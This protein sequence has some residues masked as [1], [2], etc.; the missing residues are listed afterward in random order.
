MAGPLSA[1]SPSKLNSRPQSF[2]SALVSLDSPTL[3]ALNALADPAETPSHADESIAISPPKYDRFSPILEVN[4]ESQYENSL[5]DLPSSPFQE[6]VQRDDRDQ[7]ARHATL[8]EGEAVPQ[9]DQHLEPNNPEQL[10]QDNTAAFDEEYTEN[11][12][13]DVDTTPTKLAPASE[14]YGAKS[15]SPPV[16]TQGHA[17]RIISTMTV[18][19]NKYE[20]M[21]IVNHIDEENVWGENDTL[22]EQNSTLN[23]NDDT[24]LSGFSAI[25][26][27]DMTLF[28]KLRNDSPL[29][30]T[31]QQVP[32]PMKSPHA[33]RVYKNL[34]QALHSAKRSSY[35]RDSA[36]AAMALDASSSDFSSPAKKYKRMS[37]SMDLLEFTDQYNVDSDA[38][39]LDMTDQERSRLQ[40]LKNRRASPAKDNMRRFRSP[41]KQ[42]LLDFDLPPAPT[43]RSIPSITPRELESLKSSFLSQISSLKATLSGRDAEVASF[44]EAVS[45]AERRVGEAL[46]QVRN[47]T[48]R[49]EY[50]E[51]EQREWERRGEEMESVLRRVKLDII[52]GEQEKERLAKKAEEAEKE[53][54]ELEE[55][56]VELESQLST[57]RQSEDTTSTSTSSST[58][59]AEVARQVQDA[60]ERVAREL[61]TLYKGK[62]ETKV[63]A[64]KKSYEARWSKRMKEVETKLN[65]ALKENLRLKAELNEAKVGAGFNFEGETGIS[66]GEVTILRENESLEADKRVQEAKIKG[67]EQE[68][69]SIKCDNEA[70][71]L[72]LRSERAEKGELVAVVDEWLRMQNEQAQLAQ[73]A[74]I[75]A[76]QPSINPSSYSVDDVLLEEKEEKETVPQINRPKSGSSGNA[77]SSG[78][79]PRAAP[80]NHTPR[81]PRFGSSIGPN[82]ASDNGNTALGK[83]PMAPRS[84]I[85]GSIERMG[86]GRGGS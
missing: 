64:L 13:L 84:G 75:T 82:R 78:I 34:S 41:M 17:R 79:R 21:S 67:L 49:K 36:L 5:Q 62:H 55:K 60:V 33:S 10:P 73:Q 42:S 48:A 25:P 15:N 46:E 80:Q 7:L 11:N 43:P 52:E 28:A 56:V 83:T 69:I 45:D 86:M 26:N 72:E 81:I 71:R 74:A 77:R 1:L 20:N 3:K 2:P 27:A 65:G 44:K 76:P 6:S 40:A 39:C 66:P 37:E 61:H 38:F 32:S 53:K 14:T 47:E 19:E 22:D 18:D 59:S 70:L 54:E 63:A 12:F 31:H 9:N 30:R 16:R 4:D 24:C 8:G 29:K 50:L 57:A 23:Q 58:T 85:M 68:V 35:R 51:A